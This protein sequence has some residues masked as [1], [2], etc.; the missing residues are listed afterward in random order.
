EKAFSRQILFSPYLS[1]ARLIADATP[2][3]EVYLPNQAESLLKQKEM[4]LLTMCVYGE[5][6]GEPFEGKLAIAKVI[7]NRVA[8]GGWYGRSI[9]DVVFKPYQFSCFN[10]WDPNFSKLFKPKKNVW[11]QCFKAAWNAYSELMDDPTEGATHYCV[12]RINPPWVRAME[13]TSRIGNHKFFRTNQSAV[14]EWWYHYAQA[15]SPNSYQTLEYDPWLEHLRIYAL[16]EP[17]ENA[18]QNPGPMRVVFPS[19]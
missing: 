13:E 14:S 19:F 18:N 9:K 10:T 3:G 4:T 17:I 5:A 2:N 7:M 11:K 6:R 15:P 8:Q 12:T 16:M 1:G